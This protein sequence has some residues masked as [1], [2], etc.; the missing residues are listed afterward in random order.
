MR[1]STCNVDK[2]FL[3][4]NILFVSGQVGGLWKFSLIIT[5]DPHT[6]CKLAHGFSQSRTALVKSIYLTGA[7]KCLRGMLPIGQGMKSP[8]G[9]S[10]TKKTIESLKNLCFWSKQYHEIQTLL[11]ALPGKLG[12]IPSKSSS[13]TEIP[14]LKAKDHNPQLSPALIKGILEG[15]LPL[16]K[17]RRA[18]INSSWNNIK[19]VKQMWNQTCALCSAKQHRRNHKK[20][21]VRNTMMLTQRWQ[22]RRAGQWY[23]HGSYCTAAKSKQITN[24]P[25]EQQPVI[26]SRGSNTNHT[27]HSQFVAYQSSAGWESNPLKIIPA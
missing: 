20:N 1:P 23:W 16:W 14:M 8:R 11:V 10:D 18:A 15:K 22:H 3:P 2:G 6:N 25:P 13:A 26:H 5:V 17:G 24:G 12:P 27:S 7:L 4:M 9:S 21:I 19:H